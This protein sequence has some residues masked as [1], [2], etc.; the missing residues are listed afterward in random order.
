M[1]KKRCGPRRNRDARRSRRRDGVKTIVLT[2]NDVAL[3]IRG[4]GEVVVH[5]S[6]AEPALGSPSFWGHLLRWLFASGEDAQERRQV[7][8]DDF[9]LDLEEWKKAQEPAG[10]E[11][12]DVTPEER[13]EQRRSFAHGNAALANPD[14]TR[15]DIDRAAEEMECGA[16]TGRASHGGDQ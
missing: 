5:N 1:S 12:A 13:E 9:L 2:G 14:V 4:R 7:L 10:P 15:E 8:V 3:V 11:P 16:Q 6:R